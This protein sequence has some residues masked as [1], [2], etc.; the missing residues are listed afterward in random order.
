MQI[1]IAVVVPAAVEAVNN[2]FGPSLVVAV[3]TAVEAVLALPVIM[4][5]VV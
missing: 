5:V 4:E 3:K 2:A 1:V